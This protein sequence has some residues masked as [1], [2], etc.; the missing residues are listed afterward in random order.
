VKKLYL[1]RHAKSSWDNPVPDHKR[2]LNS[3]GKKDAKL[4]GEYLK[5]RSIKIDKIQ[6][7]RS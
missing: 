3:R 4:I 7:L 5:E 6:F 2:E 1:M